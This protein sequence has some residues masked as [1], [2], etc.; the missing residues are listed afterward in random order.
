M[1]KCCIH[2][3]VR[4]RAEMEFPES[5]QGFLVQCSIFPSC[6][7]PLH[8]LIPFPKSLW[9]LWLNLTEDLLNQLFQLKHFNSI[10][11]QL[12][13]CVFYWASTLPLMGVLEFFKSRHNYLNAHLK[14]KKHWRWLWRKPIHVCSWMIIITVDPLYSVARR[15][16]LEFLKWHWSSI[17]IP[18]VFIAF[19]EV[20]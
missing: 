8:G 7:S 17:K 11:I 13:V 1:G 6:S 2:L 9:I 14:K 10:I 20:L 19:A 18:Y 3:A 4:Y 5:L 12:K 15:A 16:F